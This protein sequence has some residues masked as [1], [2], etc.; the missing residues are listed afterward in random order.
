[1][2]LCELWSCIREYQEET[3]VLLAIIYFF[4][5]KS[6]VSF[7]NVSL[8]KNLL[9]QMHRRWRL[10][11]TVGGYRKGNFKFSFWFLSRVKEDFRLYVY[12]I[13]GWKF[14]SGVQGRSILLYRLASATGGNTRQGDSSI[15]NFVVIIVF[16]CFAVF[17][18][19]VAV[20]RANFVLFCYEFSSFT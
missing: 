10:H 1:M 6:F 7:N 17:V 5:L 18:V 11:T 20:K 15:K 12:Q 9:T 2:I 16:V 13:K 19:V 8:K 14:F 4:C 3:Y